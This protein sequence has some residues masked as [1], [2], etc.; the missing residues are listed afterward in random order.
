MSDSGGEPIE[1][2]REELAELRAEVERLKAEE[3]AEERDEQPKRKR[4]RPKLRLIQ[5]GGIAALIAAPLSRYWRE[6]AAAGLVGAAATAGVLVL[7]PGHGP[8]SEDLR[9]PETSQRTT[10]PTTKGVPT[11]GRTVVPPSW[12][13]PAKAGPSSTRE[14]SSV[15]PS[16]RTGT[17]APT[18]PSERRTVEDETTV[19]PST[20]PTVLPSIP[21]P[22][23]SVPPLPTLSLPAGP[24]GC[25]VTV[26]AVVTICVPTG[27]VNASGGNHE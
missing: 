1:Q 22:S 19:L 4:R 26:G 5:G 13:P 20:H 27:E 16:Q 6:A 14:F 2:L 18:T 17:V 3:E 11:R 21:L 24:G 12:R 23:V 8:G 10:T 15:R 7:P 9:V 25:L